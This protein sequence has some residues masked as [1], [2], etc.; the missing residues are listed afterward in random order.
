[1]LIVSHDLANIERDAD[2]LLLL[3]DGEVAE[4]GQAAD[5]ASKPASKYGQALMAA[6]PRLDEAMPPLPSPG[7][8]LLQAQGLSVRFKKPGWRNGYIDAVKEVSF[9]LARGE[10]LA[11][12]GGSGSGKSTLGRAVA[13]LG[14]LFSGKI[15]WQ[16][17]SLSPRQKR[18]LEHRRL[19][20]P[21]FQDPV[22]SL[23]PRWSVT[24][25]IA[26][27]A[28]QLAGGR[29]NDTEIA[30]LLSRSRPGAG[31]RIPPGQSAF[32]RTGAARRHRPR[33][34]LQTGHAASRRG[35]FG[36][37]PA[38]RGRCFEIAS[39]ASTGARSVAA[40]Y[41]ARSRAG[42]AL[43]TQNCR[44]GRRRDR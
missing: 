18:S 20:Q 4:A 40:L 28:K 25:I 3:K 22:A 11:I 38:D 16:G 41:H 9:D 1:M 13:G 10:T 12:V 42:P 5:I 17:R 8:A 7:E 44:N 43:R 32:R 31:I 37:G 30:E 6:T 19:I 21:V 14:P 36:A 27:P 24:D 29:P 2:R 26:E 15:Y 23:N 39:P 34:F 33:P 35:Y